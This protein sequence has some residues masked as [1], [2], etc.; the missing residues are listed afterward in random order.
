MAI[1]DLNQ[2]SD[3][4]PS[5]S[6]CRS[7][8]L[9]RGRTPRFAVAISGWTAITSTSPKLCFGD[10][11]NQT[12]QPFG[13]A[14]LGRR[15]RTSVCN[16]PIH[17]SK[18]SFWAF[19]HKTGSPPLSYRRASPETPRKTFLISLAHPQGPSRSEEQVLLVL[20]NRH[21]TFWAGCDQAFRLPPKKRLGS[22][23]DAF[24]FSPEELPADLAHDAL[25]K[26]LAPYQ[27]A[28][29]TNKNASPMKHL[30]RLFDPRSLSDS[31]RTRGAIRARP[32][33]S[34][35]PWPTSPNEHLPLGLLL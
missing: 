5:L 3:Q 13:P 18:M 29:P 8:L 9:K 17:L 15:C 11:S 20:S 16:S 12:A 19:H 34:D 7:N 2:V 30:C 28:P 33:T 25:P 31:R 23:H 4:S 1:S 26:E 14:E 10:A 6:E 35:R 22:A 32:A 24:R 21:L 27:V